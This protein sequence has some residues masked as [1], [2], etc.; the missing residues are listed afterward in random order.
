MVKINQKVFNGYFRNKKVLITG[1]T[2][3]KG[4]WLSLILMKLNAKVY[5]ISNTTPK[6]N[7][8]YNLTKNKLI[9]DYQEDILNFQKLKKIIF[10]IKPDIIFHLAA[11]SLVIK[12]YKEPKDTF[13]VN[14]IG[15]LNILETVRLLNIKIDIIMITSDKAYLNV[16]KKSGYVENDKLGGKDPYSA[17]KASAEHIIEA[18]ANS[19]FINNK[20]IKIVT[21]RAGNVIGGGDWSD[22]RIV[23]D[24]IRSW[25]SKKVLNVRNPQSTRPWQHVLDPLFGYL[26]LS[27]KL[28]TTKSLNNEKFNFGPNTKKN[29]SVEE[30]LKS[31]DKSL[32]GFRWTSKQRYKLYEANLLKLNCNKA[33]KFLQ[34]TPKLN[35]DQTT[36][37]T[38]DWYK[39]YY[40]G[41]KNNC[42]KTSELQIENYIKM[43]NK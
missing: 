31:L 22:N 6:K 16:E 3:F 10:K 8:I 23:P 21:A 37:Y 13:L 35:F 27:Y 2:G 18:Y 26:L 4:S 5:G 1:H 39:S 36:R 12:S 43:I 17:S 19:Y 14:S 24:A 9:K 28:N 11:Q 15:S 30:L 25:K 33:N 34:W 42:L 20:K 29:Y 40:S 41:N 38:T 32:D 7:N